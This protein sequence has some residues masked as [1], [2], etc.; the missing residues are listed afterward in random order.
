VIE[1]R[2]ERVDIAALVDGLASRLLR[3]HVGRRADHRA[4][5]RELAGAC[6]AIRTRIEV[7]WNRVAEI[8]RESPVDHDGLTELADHDV[9]R[10]EVAMDHAMRV[11][12]RD[13]LGS[14]DHRR[15]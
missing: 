15:Q 12:V 9:R 3:W 8:L 14:D 6:A 1:D 10:L 2:A 13:R 5:D 7:L 4:Y 11:R